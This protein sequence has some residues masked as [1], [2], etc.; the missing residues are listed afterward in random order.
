MSRCRDERRRSRPGWGIDGFRGPRI[1]RWK[2]CKKAFCLIVLLFSGVWA[3]AQQSQPGYAVLTSDP[4]SAR[5]GNAI[6]AGSPPE[7]GALGGPGAG[8]IGG[9]AAPG[10]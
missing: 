6:A 3:Q 5:S 2:M 4:G 7:P 10:G 9:A 8:P 1:I